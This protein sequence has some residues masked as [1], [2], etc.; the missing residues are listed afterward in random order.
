[1]RLSVNVWQLSETHFT[2]QLASVNDTLVLQLFL[3][4]FHPVIGQV[5]ASSL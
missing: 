2:D 5:G 1:M 3:N 4:I